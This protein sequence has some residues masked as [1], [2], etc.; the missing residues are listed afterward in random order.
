[1]F[2]NSQD[3]ARNFDARDANRGRIVQTQGNV[4]D[5]QVA[6]NGA[7]ITAL[8]QGT[9]RAPYQVTVN[10]ERLHGVIEIEAECTCPVGYMCKHA[11]A[12]LYEAIAQENRQHERIGG[13]GAKSVRTTAATLSPK[14]VMW[15]EQFEKE[16]TTDTPNL[17]DRIIY[18]IMIDQEI[19][20]SVRIFPALQHKLRDGNWSR[21]RV[22]TSGQ[23]ITLKQSP[24][25]LTEDDRALFNAIDST[26]FMGGAV[27]WELPQDAP[28]ITHYLQRIIQTG[29]AFYDEDCAQPLT[30]GEPVKGILSWEL[31]ANGTQRATIKPTRSG[32]V[33][34]AMI[35]PWYLDP[36]TGETGPLL[37][38][39]EPKI[40]AQFL[41]A[42]AV[43]EK[44]ATIVRKRLSHG[45]ARI[46]APYSITQGKN[47][48]AAPIPNIVISQTCLAGTEKTDYITTARL[49]FDYNGTR[50]LP[51][52][53]SPH[54]AQT[55]EDSLLLYKRD[56]KAETAAIEKLEKLGLTIL[57]VEEKS[58]YHTGTKLV[59]I[60]S[61]SPWFWFDFMHRASQNL[62]AQGFVI[63][64]DIDLEAAIIEP[65][66]QEIDADFTQK[67]DWWFSMDLGISVGG[68]RVPLLP[69]LVGMIKK[70][71]SPSDI[72]YLLHTDKCYAPLPDGR[73]VALPAARIYTILKT[74]VELFDDKALD[75]NG[76]LRVSMDLTAAFLK[77]EAITSKRWLGEGQLR[78]IV[79]KLGDFEG[80]KKIALPKGL[81]ATLR[82]YQIE[83]YHWLNF[84]GSYGLSGILADD[85]GLGKTVQTLT[86]LQHQKEKGNL[87][88]PALI[89][90]PTSLIANW[91]AEASRFTPDL[92]IMTLHGKDRLKNHKKISSHDLIFTT[93]PLLPRD[94]DDLCKLKWSI[95]ILDE[96][97]AIKNP[98][99][100]MT[101]AACELQAK[102]RLCLTGTP[103]ENHLGEAWSI[104]TFLMP[105]LLGDHKEFTRHYR[106]PIEKGEDP[107]RKDLLA[108]RLRPFVLRRLKTE[109]AKEL[110]PKTEIIRRVTLTDDQRDLYETVRHVMN[111]RVR[112]EIAAKGLG[113]SQIV[114]LDA[115]LKLRQTCCDPRLVKLEAANKVHSSAK[116]EELMDMLPMLIEEGRKILLFSQF[117]SMLDLIKPAL[118]EAEIPYVELRGTTKDRV[119]PIT[120]FQAGE[121]PLFL[122]SLKAGGT[123]LNLTAAD[124]VI[125]YDPWWNPS[126]ENQATDR[127]HRIGQT[128]PVFVYKLIAE[129]TVEERILELQS[130]KAD[131]AGALFGTNPS[132]AAALSQDDIKWLMGGA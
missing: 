87:E 59:P 97:Q 27:A 74:L 101:Q 52:D 50:V 72:D 19:Q 117:T 25:I 129:G 118:K 131:L 124:T 81:K 17:D 106:N 65:D 67:G 88:D 78:K 37:C 69:V 23:L 29:R 46:P 80:I 36:T 132:A 48:P 99:A 6:K 98:S 112:E 22:L 12:A 125:H 119:T 57:E 73:H 47:K 91:Q 45:Q 90:M 24:R 126:V 110:P 68:E 82:H 58:L 111:D 76:Q 42:P 89:I 113:R 130:R 11:V 15:I 92:K 64:A 66:S 120:R 109:V 30:C 51:T 40:I 94:K 44:E 13:T 28:T 77:L 123:G 39:E 60:E 79:D 16:E 116:L 18:H 104:F 1:M 103:V 43:T 61:N 62:K 2:F 41:S 75:E 84:L 102:Q 85:M 35:S 107:D 10:V 115:L 127:A 31:Q 96:A 54:Y 56:I 95:I 5:I 14:L 32:L 83:G 3:I 34:L 53:A 4:K 86:Y 8:V 105:G 108:R 55:S 63:K 26:K 20:G 49:S 128:K 7:K 71:K 122:I 33:I 93:Y 9:A 21:K 38:D 70:I 100:K 114:I 121:V